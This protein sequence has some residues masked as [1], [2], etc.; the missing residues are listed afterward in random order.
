MILALATAVPCSR[1]IW[2]SQALSI[3]GALYAGRGKHDPLRWVEVLP[4]AVLKAREAAGVRGMP[5]ESAA[6]TFLLSARSVET[7]LPTSTGSRR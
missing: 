3:T 2:D 4:E 7:I 1:P 5:S 6:S